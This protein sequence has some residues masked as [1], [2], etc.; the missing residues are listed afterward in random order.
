MSTDYSTYATTTTHLTSAKRTL[1][2]TKLLKKA[3]EYLVA[4]KFATTRVLGPGEA[5]TLRLN[6]ILRA[7]RQTT[8]D[9]EGYAYGIADAKHFVTNYIDVTPEKWGD[10]F[11]WTDDTEMEVFIKQP[12]KMEEVADQMARS[13]E[14]RFQ[15][16]IAT[17]CMRYRIDGDTDYLKTGTVDSATSSTVTDAEF[18]AADF[19]GGYITV[20]NA[21]GPGYDESRNVT[22]HNTGT[23][24]ATVAFTNLLTTASK[25]WSCVGTGIVGT[26]VMSTDALLAVAY[27]HRKL[28]TDVFPNGTLNGFMHAEQE[29]DLWKNDTLWKDT[30]KYVEAS[31]YRNYKLVRWLG[32]EFLIGS[33]LHREDVDGTSNDAGVVYVAPIF[34]Q[35]AYSVVHWGLKMGS[36]KG[37]PV[38]FV[39][40]EGPDSA[41]LRD[42]FR[43]ISWKSKV[44]LYVQRGTSVIGLM[45]GAGAPTVL[46]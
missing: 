38:K 42:N 39:Y 40:K 7:A 30:A 24:V 18:A 26:D 5:G 20:T 25:I 10:S 23:N 31:R 19:T 35:K 9:T 8:Q 22:A 2:E 32:N 1:W 43:G 46:I 45:T 34:G 36:F 17:Q 14:H 28:G 13:L 27:L 21:E 41:D 4:P 37:Y 15:Q 6:K 44:V 33:E 29:Y 3:L 16:L 11:V 12:D